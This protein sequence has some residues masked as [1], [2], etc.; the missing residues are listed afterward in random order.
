MPR[1]SGEPADWPDSIGV[2]CRWTPVDNWPEW[3]K[4]KCDGDT[5]CLPDDSPERIVV[6]Q[7]DCPGWKAREETKP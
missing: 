6:P 2:L 5:W 3:A 7:V 4:D 1:E